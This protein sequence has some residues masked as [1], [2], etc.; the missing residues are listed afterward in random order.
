MRIVSVDEGGACS[1]CEGRNRRERLDSMLVGV[2]APGTWVL[3]SRGVALRVLTDEEA[4]QTNAALDALESALAGGHDFDRHF[5]DLLERA[6][7]LP[8][9][10]VKAS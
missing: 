10:F 7:P 8:G 2:Q 6:P 5:E 1:V 9:P 3:V 4:T